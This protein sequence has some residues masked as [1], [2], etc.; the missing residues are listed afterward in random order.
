MGSLLL[1]KSL[2]FFGL[3]V[4]L[5]ASGITFGWTA[6]EVALKRDK[7]FPNATESDRNTRLQAIM[8]TGTVAG[9]FGGVWRLCSLLVYTIVWLL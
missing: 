9:S 1:R 6:L 8:T 4:L 2:V 7:I 5:L 3:L